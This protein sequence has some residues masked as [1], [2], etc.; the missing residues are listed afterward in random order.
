[1]NTNDMK[2]V[3]EAAI[4]TDFV[5]IESADNVHFYA[6]VVSSAFEG[7]SKIRQHKIIMDLFHDAIADESIHA[8]SIK[9]F[10]PQ[11]W[12]QLQTDNSG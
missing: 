9:T 6:T 8:L 12:Q 3:I 2:S 5:L 4:S 7:L 10:T 11:K 1:M